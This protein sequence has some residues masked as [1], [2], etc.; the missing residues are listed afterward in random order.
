MRGIITIIVQILRVSED[1]LTKRENII[2]KEKD[3]KLK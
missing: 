3:E 2:R 1:G